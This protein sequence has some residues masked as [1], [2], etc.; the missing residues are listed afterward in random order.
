MAK[1]TYQ[2]ALGK[3]KFP[4]L[5]CRIITPSSEKQAKSKVAIVEPPF[6]GKDQRKSKKH[7]SSRHGPRDAFQERVIVPAIELAEIKDITGDFNSKRW[8]ADG[9]SGGSV[10][11]GSLRSGQDV[12]IKKLYKKLRDHKFLKEVST[13]SSMKHEN[14]AQLLGYCVEGG[15]QVLVYEFGPQGS[16]HDILHGQQQGIKGL[17]CEPG[18]ALSWAQRIEIAVG[19]AKGL[20][21]LLERESIHHNII[22]INVLLFDDGIAKITDLHPLTECSCKAANDDSVLLGRG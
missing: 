4:P 10:F 15:L 22:S 17:D 13:L 11:R 21:H 20:L 9:S 1:L 2:L 8:V 19:A 3:S 14:V 5:L 6:G 16:L 12:A 18:P 7:S